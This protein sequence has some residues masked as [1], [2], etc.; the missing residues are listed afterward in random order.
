MHTSFLDVQNGGR[1]LFVDF[2]HHIEGRVFEDP[3]I[4]ILNSRPMS[5]F[6]N[7][8]TT[9]SKMVLLGTVC[10]K[11]HNQITKTLTITQLSKHHRLWL[12]PADKVLHIA[13]V[14][15]LENTVVKLGA[16]QKNDKFLGALTQKM[17]T[18]IIINLNFS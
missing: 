16:I 1:A 9:Y 10:F 12:V 17:N 5:S 15:I 7:R 18:T 8:F 4:T 3:I 14:I 11:S 2:L 6:G 13:N